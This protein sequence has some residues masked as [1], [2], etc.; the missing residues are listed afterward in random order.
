[1]TQKF[2]LTVILSSIVLSLGGC[3]DEAKPA[4]TTLQEN[5]ILA[6]RFINAFYSFDPTEL[7]PLLSSAGE[8]KNQI[9]YYQGWAKGGNYKIVERKPCTGNSAERLICPIT[10][11]DDPMLALKT[12]FNVTD[13][14]AI[15]FTKGKIVKVEA[16]SNDQPIYYEARDWV[17]KNR[18]DIMS[19]P[20]KGFFAGGDT[21]AECARAM[22]KGYKQFMIE[23]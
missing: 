17:M 14:F 2:S 1:M 20:C 9:L 22:T 11:Q 13:T 4:M 7:S 6:E 8:S 23:Q 12:G 16:S 21:P 5:Q 15:S 10:V 19:G 3:S 18:P